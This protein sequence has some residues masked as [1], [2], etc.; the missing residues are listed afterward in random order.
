MSNTNASLAAC[1]NAT[2][3]FAARKARAQAL[4]LAARAGVLRGAKKAR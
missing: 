4:Y 1:L 3:T 2:E